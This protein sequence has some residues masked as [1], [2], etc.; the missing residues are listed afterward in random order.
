MI[1]PKVL[2]LILSGL[3]FSTPSLAGDPAVGQKIAEAECAKCHAIGKE[4]TSPLTSAPPFRTFSQKW[5]VE[6]LQEALA[7]GISVGHGPM[8]EFILEPVE[9]ADL[10]AYLLTHQTERP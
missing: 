2:L 4:G 3:C 6:D 9:I 5:P 8:P 7:E 10:I 1:R